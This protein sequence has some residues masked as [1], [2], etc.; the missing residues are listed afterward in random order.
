MSLNN[1]V[2]QRVPLQLAFPLGVAYPPYVRENVIRL[3][4][5]GD[6]AESIAAFFNG[7]PCVRTVASTRRQSSI[8]S[9]SSSSA[10]R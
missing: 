6:A 4:Q 9:A 2:L 3:H 5:R 7:R 10:I 8:A 1:P